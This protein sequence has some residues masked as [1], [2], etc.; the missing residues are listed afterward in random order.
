VWWIPL[1]GLICR[2][3]LPSHILCSSFTSWPPAQNP[4]KGT[5]TL[6][7]GMSLCIQFTRSRLGTPTLDFFFMSLYFFLFKLNLKIC[8]TD[9]IKN[10]S[11][12]QS[13]MWVLDIWYNTL[14]LYWM[15]EIY[16]FPPLVLHTTFKAWFNLC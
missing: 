1:P 16:L 11:C 9:N 6:I 13:S 2:N 5:K 12:W 3:F 14:F 4:V 7:Y 10:S 8:L 15:S